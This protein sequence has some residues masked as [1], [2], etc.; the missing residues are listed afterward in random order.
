MHNWCHLVNYYNETFYF[1]D[2]KYFDSENID[3]HFKHMNKIFDREWEKLSRGNLMIT[4]VMVGKE[5]LPDK[6][7][8]IIK[9]Y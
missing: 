7:I 8:S 6:K 5:G 1:F 3:M 4:Q 9:I 2:L